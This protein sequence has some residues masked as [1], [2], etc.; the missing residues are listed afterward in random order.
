MV[1]WS[2]VWLVL[3]IGKVVDVVAGCRQ[4]RPCDRWTV[5]WLDWKSGDGNCLQ[6]LSQNQKAEKIS[7]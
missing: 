5:G 7:S 4:D 3:D 1:G 2:S 6:G